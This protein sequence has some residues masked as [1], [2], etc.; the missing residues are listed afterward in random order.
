M[1]RCWDPCDID[2]HSNSNKHPELKGHIVMPPGHTYKL[3][4]AKGAIF[5]AEVRGD[6]LVLLPSHSQKE[7]SCECSWVLIINTLPFSHQ[8]QCGNHGTVSIPLHR[9]FIWPR[10]ATPDKEIGHIE[11]QHTNLLQKL[12]PFR[13]CRVLCTEAPCSGGWEQTNE[14]SMGCALIVSFHQVEHPT[15]SCP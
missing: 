6:G 4:D 3:L 2:G 11:G 10:G 9:L 14:H 8:G 12:K 1:P 7:L 13:E 5:P 15:T